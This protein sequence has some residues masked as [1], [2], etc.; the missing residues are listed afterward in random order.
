M[1]RLPL[2]ITMFHAFN[3]DKDDDKYDGIVPTV[4]QFHLRVSLE[5]KV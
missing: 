3:A 4:G 1:Y 2:H 5:C